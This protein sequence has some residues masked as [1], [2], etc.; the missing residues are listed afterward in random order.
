MAD[1]FVGEIRMFGG[2]FAPTGWALCNGQVM[3]ISQN[4]ALF[5]LLGTQYGG[6]GRSTFAL[7]NLQGCAPLHQGQ[8][9]GLTQRDMGE[10]GG[11][12]AVTL[13]AAQIPA[14]THIPVADAGSGN[15][16]DPTNN[17]WSTEKIGRQ[18]TN[19]YAS[20]ANA[21]MHPNAFSAAGSSQPHNNM[22][23][24][25]VVTFIIALTGIF[26]ARN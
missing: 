16:S 18:G 8:G 19:I 11:E 12:S 7:P 23:P 5:S 26:P 1:Q 13:L 17:T 14:H 15:Q 20:T 3:P 25:L 21:V 9:P 22:P 24:Y 10:T 6:D 4:T 2:N